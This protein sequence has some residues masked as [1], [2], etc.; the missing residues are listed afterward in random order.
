MSNDPATVAAQHRGQICRRGCNLENLHGAARMN[1]LPIAFVYKRGGDAARV[2]VAIGDHVDNP[3]PLHLV[4]TC[5]ILDGEPRAD[6]FVVSSVFDSFLYGFLRGVV[7]TSAAF[8]SYARELGSG[9]I[10]VVDLRSPQESLDALDYLCTFDVE[11][12]KIVPDSFSRNISHRL[13]S[14][15]GFF[16]MHEDLYAEFLERLAPI[17]RREIST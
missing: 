6:T 15:N 3:T 16:C 17:L 7:P 10:A 1:A 11:N 13:M 12:G 5:S 2:V 9:T 4:G 14:G 8:I